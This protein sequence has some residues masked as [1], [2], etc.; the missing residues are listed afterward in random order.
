MLSLTDAGYVSDE[1]LSMEHLKIVIG[2][3]NTFLKDMEELN[4]QSA[5]TG[6]YQ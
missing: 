3:T 2:V 4:Q 1:P 5:M 6:S